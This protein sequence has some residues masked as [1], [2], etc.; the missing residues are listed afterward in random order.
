MGDAR[1]YK[2]VAALRRAGCD[3]QV[4]GLGD[5]R[6]APDGCE[7]I[8]AAPA[9]KVA[10]AL[11]ALVWPW[12]VHADVLV[13]IDPDTSL[14]A[15]LATRLRRISWVADVHEDYRAV[16]RDRSWVPRPLLALLQAGVSA[17]NQL[18][19]RADLV[20]VA[21]EHVPPLHARRRY[22]MRNEPDFSLLPAPVNRVDGDG[23]RAL[24]VGD[25]RRTRGLQT[26]VEAVAVTASDAQPWELDIVG[27]CLGND[28]DWLLTRL[29]DPDC[30]G[31][32][33]HD[34]QGP[35]RSWEIGAGADVGFCLLAQTPAFTEAMPSKIYEYMA[36]GL[37]TIATPLPRVVEL[38]HSTNAGMLVE[39]VDE[40][41]EALRRFATDTEWR[42][43]LTVSARAAGEVAAG[44]RST[45]DEAAGLIATLPAR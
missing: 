36:C 30:T 21:D 14:S 39:S 4:R 22:V 29:Q 16:L 5:E 11:R 35:K 32:R 25:V 18:I 6:R 41:V 17:M 26:M 44:L 9:G 33:W 3:V 13:T 24:Y 20:L 23:W 27:P 31:I 19:A 10:R 34:R 45:Y 15:F 28:R 1:L 7:V 2:T 37:P 12:R 38:L 43:G 40:T 42:S 8:T